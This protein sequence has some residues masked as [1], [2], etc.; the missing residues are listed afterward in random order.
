M[1]R[2]EV[3]FVNDMPREL[4]GQI[5][6]PDDIETTVPNRYDMLCKDNPDT[7]AVN[8][9]IAANADILFHP[10]DVRD[11]QTFEDGHPQYYVQMFGPL[12]NGQKACVRLKV[13]PYFD[14]ALNKKNDANKLATEI[15][16]SL[17]DHGW[18][19]ASTG[20]VKAKKYMKYSRHRTTY[21]RV[22]MHS[23]SERRK[24]ITYCRTILK[25]ELGSVDGGGQGYYKVVAAQNML[26][27]GTWLNIKKYDS[28]F[29]NPRIKMKKIF[30][31]TPEDISVYGGDILGLKSLR[32]DKTVM[33]TWDIETF[34][35]IE[36]MDAEPPYPNEDDSGMF[37]VSMNAH[38]I[39]NEKPFMNIL[40]TTC[41]QLA[42]PDTLVILCNTE[43]ELIKS[44]VNV[45]EKIDPDIEGGFNTGCYD[46]PWMK[47]RMLRYE[48]I[49]YCANKMSNVVHIKGKRQSSLDFID[50]L[51]R[52]NY[53]HHNVKLDAD[54]GMT[55]WSFNFPGCVGI[56]LMPTFR[57]THM[58]QCETAG[59]YNLNF[60][61]EMYGLQLKHDVK[62]N[63]M[64]DAYAEM[65]KHMT[66]DT[67]PPIEL[68][69]LL[70]K[71]GKYCCNDTLSTYLLTR[72]NSGN[73][74]PD[75]R[76]IANMSYTSL[77]D[78][79]WKAGGMKV[80][81]LIIAEG[82]RSGFIY[83]TYSEYKSER[84]KYI[85]GFVQP[86][87]KGVVAAKMS[88][89]ERKAHAD[90]ADQYKHISDSDIDKMEEAILKNNDPEIV[91]SLKINARQEFDEFIKGDQHRPVFA[92]DFESL[93]PSIII[94][95]N[96]DPTT[97]IFDARL[98]KKMIASG[99]DLYY[100][101]FEHL[102]QK[103][104][105]W[106]KRHDG[107]EEDMAVGPRILLRLFRERA[108]LKKTLGKLDYLIELIHAGKL[109]K[110]R[111]Q[112]DDAEFTGV[113]LKYA[114]L[115]EF[116][117]LPFEEIEYMHRYVD[118]KQKARKVFMN[119]FYGVMGDPNSPFF[120]LDIAATITSTGQRLIK[121]ARDVALNDEGCKQYYGDTDSIYISSNG[122][123]FTELDRL[124]YGGQ[125]SKM[126]YYTESVKITMNAA[127]QINKR[128]NGRIADEVGNAF[129]RMAFEEVLWPAV[130]LRKKVYFGIAHEKVINFILKSIDDA[131]L[132]GLS[133]IKRGTAPMQGKITSELVMDILDIHN[134]KSMK[135]LVAEKVADAYE[136]KWD[137][138]DFMKSA[139]YKPAR[140]GHPGN[141]SILRFVERMAA[142][143]KHVPRPSERIQYV[144]TKEYPWSYDFRGCQT[145]LL[146]GDKLWYPEDIEAENKEIDMAYYMTNQVSG[147]FAQFLSYCEEFHVDPIDDTDEALK[148]ADKKIGENAKAWINVLNNE[149]S[150]TPI[151]KG[152]ALK[153]AY[154][155]TS[156][157]Y[158]LKASGVLSKQSITLFK[159]K[160]G[161]DLG[162]LYQNT[163]SMIKTS[164]TKDAANYAD[165]YVSR[166]IKENGVDFIYALKI[167]YNAGSNSIY[168]ETQQILNRKLIE[169]NDLF[170]VDLPQ[171]I[172]M[173]TARNHTLNTVVNMAAESM[174]LDK[175]IPMRTEDLPN[176]VN[177][178]R[179][180]DAEAYAA[181][182]DI[183]YTTVALFT[184]HYN[185]LHVMYANINK[186]D[187]I[188][189]EI[190]FRVTKLADKDA[191]PPTIN[192]DDEIKA[193][194]EFTNNMKTL[195]CEM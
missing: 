147:Q 62:P 188:L 164:A 55:V 21:L 151:N 100:S 89:R 91:K 65:D 160:L 149:H 101:S 25:Y 166:V 59:K 123:L 70:T 58:K 41:P 170:I 137:V 66:N 95:Y 128:I 135:T 4:C 172:N 13:N 178:T 105:L 133:I 1:D 169:A 187:A 114:D 106:F 144:I 86:P 17:V 83:D 125:M 141:K 88:F 155:R 115:A 48:I 122:K 186:N 168:N 119:T 173:F 191:M 117:E 162:Q 103:R 136:R 12:L 8:A 94:A 27:L 18:S 179:C 75:M 190:N 68:L 61:L 153:K 78:A 126:E 32:L 56:D 92:L 64:F 129:L 176:P 177:D 165:A 159:S 96:V 77:N 33:L 174:E 35:N 110:F 82:T 116:A 80:R 45:W 132:K 171:F 181:E 142:L 54:N 192:V 182:H 109:E 28:Y 148:A 152:S 67:Q 24:A 175:L 5:I 11:Y 156:K 118:S 85:G 113:R 79:V 34:K 52:Y 26:K 131:F 134:T 19:V 40:I 37:Q 51:I 193:A 120:D 23:S 73:S 31:T 98:A 99:V 183:D 60:F 14:I 36:R 30:T 46:W 50:N 195:I 150:P 140:P 184:E 111:T 44:F 194:T 6:A 42:E 124:Y 38:I 90:F 102:G 93:Y 10:N 158:Y 39:R 97:V 53:N 29:S 143:G 104:E 146:T 76:E 163:I 189:K 15:I 63:D 74:I 3:D 108:Q 180:T 185:T 71:I 167:L 47:E 43:E 121:F 9:S 16:N 112:P 2:K 72:V 81:N 107:T 20:F 154:N 161:D 87:L 22:Y 57:K 145:K 7:A 84:V 138:G 139:T 69:E 49:P 130:F 157:P 127:D